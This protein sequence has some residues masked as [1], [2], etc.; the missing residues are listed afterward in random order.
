M[1]RYST[2]GKPVEQGLNKK[3][4]KP[5]KMLNLQQQVR[6]AEKILRGFVPPEQKGGGH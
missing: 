6:N 3:T 1:S 4:N 2:G 5:A